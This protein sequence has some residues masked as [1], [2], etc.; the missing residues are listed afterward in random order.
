MIFLENI[1]STTEIKNIQQQ[2]NDM[3]CI[4][5]HSSSGVFIN[6][7]T[8]LPEEIN[9]IIENNI[10]VCCNFKKL[11]SAIACVRLVARQGACAPEP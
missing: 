6:K 2:N 8:N 1:L 10:L 7:K 9:S 5:S 3:K 11:Q 4:I